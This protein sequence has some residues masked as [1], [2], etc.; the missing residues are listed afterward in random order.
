MQYKRIEGVTERHNFAFV[1]FKGEKIAFIAQQSLIDV[2]P[3]YFPKV[4]PASPKRTNAWYIYR[5]ELPQDKTKPLEGGVTVMNHE[6]IFSREVAV[7]M[8][9]RMAIAE[10]E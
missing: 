2:T 4:R 6:P 9:E 1:E 7:G 5:L 3:I 10:K 8:A